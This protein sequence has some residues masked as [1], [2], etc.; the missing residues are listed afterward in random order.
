M[1]AGCAIGNSEEIARSAGYRLATGAIK[2]AVFGGIA[3][4][5]AISIVPALTAGAALTIFSGVT[6]GTG[7]VPALNGIKNDSVNF[8]E[9]SFKD[10][11]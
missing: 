10:F 11:Q 2:G 3:A 4:A 1:A 9:A 6:I 8:L 7:I 5:V